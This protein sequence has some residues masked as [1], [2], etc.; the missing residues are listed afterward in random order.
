M[1]LRKWLE[2]NSGTKENKSLDLIKISKQRFYFNQIF[3][4]FTKQ[5]RRQNIFST[6]NKNN[7]DDKRKINKTAKSSFQVLRTF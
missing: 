6:K 1:L 5:K 7:K 2:L 4:K 3:R